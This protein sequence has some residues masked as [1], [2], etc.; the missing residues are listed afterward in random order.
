MSVE[1][2]FP[3][4]PASCALVLDFWFADTSEA[5]MERNQHDI[6]TSSRICVEDKGICEAVQRNLAAGPYTDGVLAPRHE[7]GVADFQQRVRA[8]REAGEGR[9]AADIG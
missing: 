5:A 6:D 9:G 3:T 2:W 1:R 8:A 7:A 4:G